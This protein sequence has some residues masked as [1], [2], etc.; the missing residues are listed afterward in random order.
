MKQLVRILPFVCVLSILFPAWSAAEFVGLD[1]D[2]D[3]MCEPSDM[4]YQ[5]GPADVDMT[6]TIGVFFDEL[7]PIY[8]YGCTFCVTDKDKV[9][10][11]TWTYL[12][13]EGWVSVPLMDSDNPGFP[14]VVSAFIEQRYPNYLCWLAQ[15]YDFTFVNPITA[16]PTTVGIFEYQVAEEGCV[17]F[18]IDTGV[19]STSVQSTNFET[20]AFDA[21]GEVCDTV[22]CESV[23][24]TEGASWGSVKSL[25]R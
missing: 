21:P 14:G 16:Y 12:S 15:N 11:W 8:G 3:Q 20:F 17:Q 1:A 18:V 13:P 25:F 19:L 23:T 10:D 2:G 4:I 7:P 6:R 24:G 9:G 5:A 22:P